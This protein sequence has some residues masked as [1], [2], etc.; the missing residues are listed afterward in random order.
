MRAFVA[1]A[2]LI[3]APLRSRLPTITLI[4]GGVRRSIRATSA[5]LTPGASATI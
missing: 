4:V 2:R 1:C 5:L 3:N